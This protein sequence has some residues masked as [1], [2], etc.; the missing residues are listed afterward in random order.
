MCARAPPVPVRLCATPQCTL[1]RS[2]SKE[3]LVSA[4]STGGVYS[5]ASCGEPDPNL[6]LIGCCDGSV[7]LIDMRCAGADKLVSTQAP[8]S[9]LAVMLVCWLPFHG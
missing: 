4:V 5:V 9:Q 8:H 6:A 2:G 3:A 1:A 7:N